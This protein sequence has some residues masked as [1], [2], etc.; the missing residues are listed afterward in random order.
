MVFLDQFQVNEQLHEPI[1]IGFAGR[2][3][4]AKGYAYLLQ[5]IAELKDQPIILKLRG[6]CQFR[7]P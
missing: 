3:H 7:H 5:V 1:T 6:W 2:Y 4:T